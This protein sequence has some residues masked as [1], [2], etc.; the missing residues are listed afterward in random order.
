MSLQPFPPCRNIGTTRVQAKPLCRSMA[1]AIISANGIRPR[2]KNATPLRRRTGGQSPASLHR[3]RQPDAELTIVELCAAYLDFAE[4]YY[5][6]DGKPDRLADPDHGCDPRSKET[7]G[8][9][10]AADFGPLGFRPSSRRSSTDSHAGAMSTSMVG[11]HQADVQ[12]GRQ[13]E[14][15][16]QPAV[17]Q[18]LRTVEGLRKGR[19]TPARPKPI[20]PVADEVVEATLPHLPMVVADMVRF[21][22]L[23]GCRPG[24][25]C[26]LRPCDVDRSGEV[27][28]YRP[29]SPQDGAPRPG[30]DHLH[31]PQGPGHVPALPA[32]GRPGPLLPAGRERTANATRSKRARRRTRVQPSQWNR[33]KAQPKRLQDHL[34]QGPYAQAISRGVEKANAQRRKEAAEQGRRGRTAAALESQ[35][36]TPFQGDGDTPPSS[37]WRPPR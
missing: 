33:R 16:F 20:L 24:E 10:P 17:Y 15:W 28:Q 30:A 34:H 14:N 25:V 7:Y 9:T 6:K 19:T 22:R 27:W 13:R 32:A 36:A 3:Y 37:A 31:R 23:T 8:P 12:V 4:G 1:V 18:P 5:V 2:A 26:Q 21:Q 29:E 35:P 11:R